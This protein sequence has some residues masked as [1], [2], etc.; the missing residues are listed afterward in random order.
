V[1]NIGFL[2]GLILVAQSCKPRSSL[3]EMQTSAAPTPNAPAKALPEPV[4]SSVVETTVSAQIDSIPEKTLP[5]LTLEQR[6]DKRAVTDE[7]F[8]RGELY[9]WTTSEQINELRQTKMLLVATGKT[10]GAPSPYSR[11]LSQLANGKGAG[12]SVAKLLSEHAGLTKRRYAWPNPFATA[13]PLGERSY[14]HA[15]VH[16]VLKEEAVLVKLD[17][18]EKDPFVFVDLN[19]K[20][21]S[22]DDIVQHPER[23]AAV[24]HVRRK[25]EGGPRFREYIVC[26]ESMIARW[27]VDTSHEQSIV[28]QESALITELL[29]SPLTSR[30]GKDDSLD[31]NAA[32]SRTLDNPTLLDKWRATL[33]FDSPKYKPST[34]RLAAISA[35]LAAY[36]RTGEPLNHTPSIAFPEKPKP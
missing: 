30:L 23:I 3:V 26:N 36:E 24:F 31:A 19:N 17:P 10:H 12:Q 8:A 2:L 5:P 22:L 29:Q 7:N 6:L 13:V 27:S 35:S 1:K 18:L 16:I 15:L 28:E 4:S 34:T 21:V 11:L 33:A 14:G 25:P 20:S 9:S 32:W